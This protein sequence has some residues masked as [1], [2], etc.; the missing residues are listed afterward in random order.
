MV[1]WVECRASTQFTLF[2]VPQGISIAL[3]VQSL[4]LLDCDRKLTVCGTSVLPALKS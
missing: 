3:L 4:D 2:S 1:R